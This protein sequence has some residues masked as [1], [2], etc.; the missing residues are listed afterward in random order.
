MRNILF[1]LLLGVLAMPVLGQNLESLGK[2]NPAETNRKIV[3]KLDAAVVLTDEQETEVNL[4]LEAT[5]EELASVKAKYE[6]TVSLMREDLKKI[7]NKYGRVNDENRSQVRTEIKLVRAEYEP[8][9]QK[10]RQEYEGIKDEVKADIKTIL[11]S[12]QLAKL[13]KLNTERREK[14]RN[15][16]KNKRNQRKPVGDRPNN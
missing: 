8:E 14:F 5:Q 6:P 15:R 7:R 10:M 13:K 11:S 4:L 2:G 3:E 9:L 16:I 12:D 1:T